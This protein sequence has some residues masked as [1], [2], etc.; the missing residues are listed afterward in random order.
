M[1][2]LPQVRLLYA[3]WD[4]L[5]TLPKPEGQASWYTRIA[6]CG[7]YVELPYRNAYECVWEARTNM[8]PDDLFEK[9]N[10]GD[11]EGLRI[12]SMSVGDIVEIGDR[13]FICKSA[14]WAEI[15]DGKEHPWPAPPPPPPTAWER[16]QAGS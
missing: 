11:R 10:V 1:L 16:I 15:I 5:N 2:D 3:N 7:E 8:G 13:R 4:L 12:R 9:F 14:G 6:I